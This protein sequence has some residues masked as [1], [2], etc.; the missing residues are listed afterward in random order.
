MIRIA[1]EADVPEI[2]AIYAPYVI[3]TTYSFEYEV[4]SPEAFLARFRKITAQ[5]P[6]LV[7]EEQGKILGYAYGSLPFERSGYAWIAEVS[8]YLLPESQGKG[9]GRRLYAALEQLLALQGYHL[10]YS[11]ITGVNTGSITFHEKTGY[12]FLADFPACGYKH[13][14]SLNVIWMEKRL[15]SVEIP[16]NPPTPWS[17]LVKSDGKAADILA[18][19]TL[20]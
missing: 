18:I 15:Q 4:P 14:K 7:W 2:L 6:W 17:A 3:N 12:T 16:S 11:I 5:F 8:I 10:L 19:L 1:T 20:S 13:G 9:L